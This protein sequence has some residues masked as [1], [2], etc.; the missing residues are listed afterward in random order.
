MRPTQTQTNSDRP[1][2]GK[3]KGQ[4]ASSFVRGSLSNSDQLR[5]S[6]FEEANGTSAEQVRPRRCVG[7]KFEEALS[8]VCI[9]RGKV[10]SSDLILHL[11]PSQ[12]PLNPDCGNSV[13]TGSA[14]REA[15]APNDSMVSAPLRPTQ[16]NSDLPTSGKR[17][18]QAPSSFTRGALSDSHP[19]KHSHPSAPD[20]GRFLLR[21]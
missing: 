5:P 18:G 19:R 13:D 15:P 6:D 11:R 1:T 4:P 10:S 12:I 8:P 14:P 16:T 20:G 2:S 9:R 7:L 17:T 3:W 21:I